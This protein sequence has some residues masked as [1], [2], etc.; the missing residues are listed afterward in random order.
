LNE[1]LGGILPCQ[2]LA[3]KSEQKTACQHKGAR[4]QND[5]KARVHRQCSLT[6][7][8]PNLLAGVAMIRILGELGVLSF[9]HGTQIRSQDDVDLLQGQPPEADK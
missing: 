1:L 6:N 5:Q 2:P 9:P 3:S 7:V 4:R 8:I